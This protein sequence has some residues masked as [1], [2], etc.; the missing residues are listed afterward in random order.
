MCDDDNKKYLYSYDKKLHF[1]KGKNCG[2]A[3]LAY[4][5]E[6]DGNED[7]DTFEKFFI[8]HN[9]IGDMVMETEQP[10]ESNIEVIKQNN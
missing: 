5:D 10:K 1:Y 8:R 3:L 2:W 4:D 6:W 7:I 9:M